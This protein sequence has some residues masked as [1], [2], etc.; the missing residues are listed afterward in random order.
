[1]LRR[2]VKQM[3]S[4]ATVDSSNRRR[5]TIDAWGDNLS[6][7]L[8]TGTATG[9]QSIYQL[10]DTTKI[11]NWIENKWSYFA[12]KI[13][14]GT[15]VDQTRMIASN[16]ST[17]L[18][19]VQPWTTAPDATSVYGIYEATMPV[20][21]SGVA[22]GTQG[23]FTLADTK[24][25]WTASAWINYAVRIVSAK[26]GAQFRLITANTSTVL[27]YATPWTPILGITDNLDTGTAT[28]EQ[29]VTT[30]VDTAKTW[31]TDAWIGYVLHITS[32]TG[33]DQAKLIA[34]NTLDTLNFQYPWLIQPDA[35]S[36]YAI[37][38]LPSDATLSGTASNPPI[39]DTLFD[40]L[41][42]SW[43]DNIWVDYLIKI[44]SGSGAGQIRQIASNTATTLT[45]TVAWRILPSI[46]STYAIYTITDRQ[47]SISALPSASIDVGTIAG[48]PR[49]ALGTNSTV[50]TVS[51]I[52]SIDAIGLYAAQQKFGDISHKVYNDSIRSQ[53]TFD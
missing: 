21:D 13:T 49:L 12:V 45:V 9:T 20:L 43:T 39:T 1:M 44:T 7:P 35:S 41:T 53:L 27:T 37:R 40:D 3:E 38:A 23:L 6:G 33:I 5:I 25:V 26:E 52:S 16:S 10:V 46:D 31:T 8:E 22:L 30:F 19:L 34:S 48:M 29:S 47:Y 50:G 42:K 14:A 4:K 32:G 15:G 24:K 28:G 11:F 17:A 2:I 18:T 51:S 36:T